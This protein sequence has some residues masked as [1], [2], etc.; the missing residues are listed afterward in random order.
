[1]TTLQ[2]TLS[3]IKIKGNT[4]FNSIKA[5]T[6]NI[7]SFNNTYPKLGKYEDYPQLKTIKFQTPREENKSEKKQSITKP[8]NPKPTINT[9]N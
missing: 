8:S 1:M 4:I 6:I 3:H 9:Q 5:N 2:L 7:T